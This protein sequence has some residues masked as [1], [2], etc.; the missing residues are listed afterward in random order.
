MISLAIFLA[1]AAEP[2][3]TPL[4]EGEKAPFTG[5]LFP[6]GRAEKLASRAE[7]CEFRLEL[8][9]KLLEDTLKLK[10]QALEAQLELQVQAGLSKEKLLTQALQEAQEAGRREWWEQPAVSGAIGAGIGVGVVVGAVY[11]L[12]QLR[13][14]L[15]P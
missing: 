8:N 15:P 13:P 9:K 12:A 1:L 6:S 11:L 5:F 3:V 2:E 4:D 14:S 10:T 7:T